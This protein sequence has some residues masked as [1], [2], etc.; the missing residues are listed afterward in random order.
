PFPLHCVFLPYYKLTDVIKT[1]VQTHFMHPPC[2][3]HNVGSICSPYIEH[4]STEPLIVQ[5]KIWI[6]SSA[7]F[8]LP[9]TARTAVTISR[10][11]ATPRLVIGYCPASRAY[12]IEAANNTTKIHDMFFKIFSIYISPFNFSIAR[13]LQNA[14]NR[15]NTAFFVPESQIPPH[16]IWYNRV[17]QK[18]Y[19]AIQERSY[20][21]TYDT[22]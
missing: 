9:N 5:V 16:W 8:R 10:T 11:A 22:I 15:I 13:R 3:F 4:G 7:F 19:T 18:L 17:V 6:Y 21:D 1:Q 14:T 2:V 20:S 12:I